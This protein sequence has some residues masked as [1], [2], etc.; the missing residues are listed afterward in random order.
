MF[1]LKILLCFFFVPRII[2]YLRKVLKEFVII[3]K[4]MNKNLF[5]YKVTNVSSISAIYQSL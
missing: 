1:E 5:S 2:I 3:I 4:Y